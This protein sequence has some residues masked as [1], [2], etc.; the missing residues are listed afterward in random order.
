MAITF[1][2]DESTCNFVIDYLCSMQLSDSHKK[3]ETSNEVYEQRLKEIEDKVC[4]D[5]N[6]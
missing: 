3:L 4:V 2:A 6:L 5:D 1:C